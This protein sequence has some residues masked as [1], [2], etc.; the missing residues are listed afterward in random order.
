[1]TAIFFITSLRMRYVCGDAGNEKSPARD[2]NLRAFYKEVSQLPVL[3]ILI[4][5]S[6]L[7]LGG[8]LSRFYKF[9]K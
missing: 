4:Q 9:T 6:P 2:L 1:V 3:N 8:F 7:T 5:I